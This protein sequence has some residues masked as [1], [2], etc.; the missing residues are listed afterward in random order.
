MSEH[1]PTAERKPS[2][3]LY[4]IGRLFLADILAGLAILVIALIALLLTSF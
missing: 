2:S 3:W 4:R 1:V